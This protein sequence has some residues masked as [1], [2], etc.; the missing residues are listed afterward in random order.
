VRSVMTWRAICARPSLEELLNAF[1]GKVLSRLDPTVRALLRRIDG[2]FRAVMEA[3]N[4]PRAV[5]GG[6]ASATPLAGPY[7]A[8]VPF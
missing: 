5:A 8:L 3:A 6:A 7:K 4:L 1:R 2:G